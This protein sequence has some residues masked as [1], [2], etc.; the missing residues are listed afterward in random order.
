LGG[1]LINYVVRDA[2]SLIIGKLGLWP[3]I[4]YDRVINITK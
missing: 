1:G 4:P 2:G 3:R